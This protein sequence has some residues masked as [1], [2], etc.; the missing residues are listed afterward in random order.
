MADPPI[1]DAFY[2]IVEWQSHPALTWLMLCLHIYT[3]LI[4]PAWQ[5]PILFATFFAILGAA[6][7][8]RRNF[9][10]TQIYVQN[11]VVI[12]E[13]QQLSLTE[14][15]KA[16]K[17]TAV[18][19]D[20]MVDMYAMNFE[21]MNN[22]FTWADTTTTLSVLLV[23][24]LV[25]FLMSYAMKLFTPSICFFL[26]GLQLFYPDEL[27]AKVMK[28]INEINEKYFNTKKVI[29]TSNTTIISKELNGHEMSGFVYCQDWNKLLTIA[30]KNCLIHNIKKLEKKLD[31]KGNP[32]A[33]RYGFYSLNK[34]EITNIATLIE[35]NLPD[36]ILDNNDTEN[37]SW[38]SKWCEVWLGDNPVIKVSLTIDDVTKYI[39][40][41][42]THKKQKSKETKEYIKNLTES[43]ILLIELAGLAITMK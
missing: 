8:S 43:T 9:K 16:A 3:F 12:E 2:D 34:D 42:S 6:T 21:R 24:F 27:H 26:V 10:N 25:A 7:A 19:I 39:Y 22:I 40:N 20:R 23:M 17:S 14:M 11:D 30:A 28:Y 1:I 18:Y 36:N 38:S 37:V 15:Y 13:D 32:K 5:F 33:P 4:A 29:I 31:E 41:D 35:C